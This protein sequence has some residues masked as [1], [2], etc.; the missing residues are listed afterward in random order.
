[1]LHP[2]C[3]PCSLTPPPPVVVYQLR[4]LLQRLV[5]VEAQ[6]SQLQT[7]TYERKVQ[8]LVQECVGMVESCGTI[9]AKLH[10]SVRNRSGHERLAMPGA[11]QRCSA[12]KK[13]VQNSKL[14][15]T[16]YGGYS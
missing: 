6:L 14:E 13:G 8:T 12:H 11:C 7:R 10:R 15:G 4:L 2:A 9:F 3:D 1:M 5:S 16:G